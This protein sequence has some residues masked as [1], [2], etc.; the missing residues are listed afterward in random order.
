MSTAE[1]QRRGEGRE[2]FKAVGVGAASSG[3][4]DF[5]YRGSRGNRAASLSEL[6]ESVGNFVSRRL[7][8]SAV[9]YV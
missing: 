1:A 8:V 9:K 4:L 5:A 7:G 6:G 3:F 2:K